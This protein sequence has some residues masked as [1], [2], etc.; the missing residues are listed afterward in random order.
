[1]QKLQE[2]FTQPVSQVNFILYVSNW[3]VS[4]Y[5]M[6]YGNISRPASILT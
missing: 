5:G 1:M 4:A 6:F 2:D 3:A